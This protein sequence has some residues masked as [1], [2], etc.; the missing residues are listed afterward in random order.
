MTSADAHQ[1]EDFCTGMALAAAP[2]A[3]LLGISLSHFYQLH[4]TGRPG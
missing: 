1:D 3:R 4:K 2:A